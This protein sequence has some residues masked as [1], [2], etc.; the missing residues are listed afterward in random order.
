MP[1]F[2]ISFLSI[3]Q[4]DDLPPTCNVIISFQVTGPKTGIDL[5]Q[6]YALNVEDT[7]PGGTSDIVDSVDMTIPESQYS[8]S[9][10]LQTGA[11]YNLALCPRTEDDGVLSDEVEGE[12]WETFCV[13]NP[14]TTQSNAGTEAPLVSIVSNEPATLLH[15]NQIT[16]SWRS[17][18]YT[19]GNVLW[20]PQSEPRRNTYPFTP[21]GG[22]PPS[23]T[24]QYTAPIPATLADQALSFTVEVENKFLEPGEFFPTTV[25]VRSEKN[26][27]SLRQFLVA[28]N[29]AFPTSVKQYMHG[30]KSLRALMQI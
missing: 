16:I 17:Y 25:I 27:T 2:Q 1:D 18:S 14:Y 3:K 6:V 30:T 8:S 7:S 23:Y 9:V 20:G 12:P 22:N 15:P 24:G 11:S 4:M 13:I 5:V 26:Y 21:I 28:S 19:D 10:T 29:V